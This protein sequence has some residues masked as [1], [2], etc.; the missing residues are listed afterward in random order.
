MDVHTALAL[1]N[2]WPVPNYELVEEDVLVFV[3]RWKIHKYNIYRRISDNTYWK[4]CYK[5]STTGEG[6]GINE[7]VDILQVE[8][9]QELVTVYT[10]VRENNVL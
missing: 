9:A 1:L 5:E 8:P 4:V 3:S 10:T 2:S 7:G 6:V